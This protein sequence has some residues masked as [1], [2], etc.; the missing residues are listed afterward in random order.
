MEIHLRLRRGALGDECGLSSSNEKEKSRE[1]RGKDD[2]VES[3]N[4]SQ[5]KG[6]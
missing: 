4:R 5:R 1:L 3:K 2:H 6:E